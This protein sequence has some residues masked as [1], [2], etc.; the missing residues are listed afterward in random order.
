MAT[1]D[2]LV[3]LQML[4]DR[5]EK[6]SRR[7]YLLNF[8]GDGSGNLGAGFCND[9]IVCDWANVTEAAEQFNRLFAQPPDP[10]YTGW[11]P[12]V[13]ES[14][15]VPDA[16]LTLAALAIIMR[17]LDDGAKRQHELRFYGDGSGLLYTGP[18]YET[19]SA[20]WDA[21]DIAAKIID[22]RLARY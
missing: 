7:T 4:L 10:K 16:G 2:S 15:P 9:E 5:L 22:K 6:H 18:A 17:R 13:D 14:V 20:E 11:N 8:Y 19:L 21:V 12:R 1:V 3:D